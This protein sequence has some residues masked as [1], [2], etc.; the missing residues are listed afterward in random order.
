MIRV[1]QPDGSGLPAG[2]VPV[3]FIAGGGELDFRVPIGRR[4]PTTDYDITWAPRGMAAIPV[5]D[6]PVGMGDRTLTDFR[7]ISNGPLTID[8]QAV[9]ILTL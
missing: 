3:R 7:V 5:F 4:M 1:D 8:D 6:F 2:S 9:F